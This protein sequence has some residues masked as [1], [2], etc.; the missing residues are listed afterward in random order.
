[1]CFH[2]LICKKCSLSL[3]Q[4]LSL[5]CHSYSIFKLTSS[6]RDKEYCNIQMV[7]S[8]HHQDECWHLLLSLYM[9]KK[10]MYCTVSSAFD[11]WSTWLDNGDSIHLNSQSSSFLVVLMGLNAAFL[12][13]MWCDSSA[14]TLSLWIIR[15]KWNALFLQWVKWRGRTWLL[16]HSDLNPNADHVLV[17]LF[18]G[19]N[20]GSIFNKFRSTTGKQRAFLNKETV[21]W[22]PRKIKIFLFFSCLPRS[23][24]DWR[25]S[26]GWSSWHYCV[27]PRSWDKNL[28]VDRRQTGDSN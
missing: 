3:N 6:G 14:S 21:T 10:K 23:N 22:F 26:A 17:C 15:K 28:G 27:S 25:S 20:L 12:K 16:T 19:Q 5:M 13:C 4:Y 11:G 7:I 8:Q 2:T 18:L 9:F 24:R 1:M